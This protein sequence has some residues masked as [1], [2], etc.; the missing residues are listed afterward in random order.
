MAI[1]TEK[2]TEITPADILDRIENSDFP[3]PATFLRNGLVQG[4]NRRL[5]SD[6]R[7]NEFFDRLSEEGLLDVAYEDGSKTSMKWVRTDL[8]S[9]LLNHLNRP[10]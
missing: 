9:T 5:R 8:G 7:A 3:I 10:R 6:D 4:H 1:Q 2:P